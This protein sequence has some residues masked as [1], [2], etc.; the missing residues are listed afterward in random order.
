MGFRLIGCT[1][2]AATYG[3][4]PMN[5]T[6]RA[7]INVLAGHF[8]D[9]NGTLAA[10]LASFQPVFGSQPGDFEGAMTEAL[11]QL[12][13]HITFQLKI[14]HEIRAQTIYYKP[15]LSGTGTVIGHETVGWLY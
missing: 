15:I 9:A 11:N 2:L 7:P 6:Q 14:S 8:D 1:L 10:A 4:K 13:A 3:A 12:A 5:P